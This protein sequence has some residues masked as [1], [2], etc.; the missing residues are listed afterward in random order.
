MIDLPYFDLL[1]EGR[2]RGDPAARA[3]E[4][5]VH[6]GYWPDPGKARRDEQDFLAAMDRLNNELL[7]AAEIRNG[8]SVLDAG[9]GFGGTIEAINKRHQSM[10]LFGL[11]IDPRQVEVAMKQ[12]RPGYDN[13][14][15]FLVGDACAMPFQGS[16]FHR[17]LAV[18]CIFHFPSRF[19]F[20]KE[21]SRVLKPGGILVLSDFVPQF[22]GG[23]GAGWIQRMIGRGY[24]TTG[25][26]WKEGDYRRM[27][28]EVRLELRAD[29]DVTA[30]TLPTYPMLLQLVRQSRLP[31]AAK[32]VWPTRLLWAVSALRLVR[33]RIL[34]FSKPNV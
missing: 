12:V 16:S 25:S 4:R 18:E 28:R 31:Q 24:G 13:S 14:I 27:A 5:Y 30:N 21:A 32:M 20:L 11:N 19:Q 15:R 2:K 17:V 6:W 8:Q 22:M 7:T 1:L 29:R 33:Y 10:S 9:C 26:D 3:F 34:V 23:G